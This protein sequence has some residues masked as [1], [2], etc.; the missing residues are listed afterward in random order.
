M[1]AFTLIIT[2]IQP[3]FHEQFLK[4]QYDKYGT[5]K[6]VINHSAHYKS[7]IMDYI[8]KIQMCKYCLDKIQFAQVNKKIRIQT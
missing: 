3:W 4:I 1:N 8:S 6:L 2:V 7:Y 5:I